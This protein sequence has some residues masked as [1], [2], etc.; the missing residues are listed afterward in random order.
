MNSRF[1]SIR[2]IGEKEREFRSKLYGIV[3]FSG[4]K[5]CKILSNYYYI[6]NVDNPSNPK[7][8]TN[9]LL[10]ED[11]HPQISPNKRFLITD[12]YADKNGY[13]KL[14][15]LDLKTDQV[16]KIGEF[17]IADYLVK[18]KLKYDLHPRWDNSGKLINFDSSH[19][20]SRQNFVIDITKLL[21]E[22][23]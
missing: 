7:K 3:Q 18:N 23:G 2:K 1:Q 8:I 17:K 9:K 6:I 16:Y 11:G 4:Q 21:S 22:I 15:L 20:G 5:I 12:T 10:N 14:F 19:L 13:L